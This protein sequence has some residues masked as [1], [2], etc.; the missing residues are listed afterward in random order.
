MEPSHSETSSESVDLEKENLK[1]HND[2]LM[3][4][5]KWNAAI[6]TVLLEQAGGVAEVSAEDLQRID[7]SKANATVEYDSERDV[8]VI[9]GV[10][11]D[12]V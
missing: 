1:L 8:Y 9:K 3:E 7:L 11:E 5:L 2:E 12:A 4:M 6:V 10:Y